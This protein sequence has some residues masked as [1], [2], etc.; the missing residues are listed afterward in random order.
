MTTQAADDVTEVRRYME[1][2]R[3]FQACM[4]E[5]VRQTPDGC[6]DVGAWLQGWDEAKRLR[7]K[8]EP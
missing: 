2:E 3:G 6:M 8:G 5:A 1:Y 4:K 7:L